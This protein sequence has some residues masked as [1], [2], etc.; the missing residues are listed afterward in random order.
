MKCPHT[1]KA[2]DHDGAV[3]CCDCG[4][5]VVWPPAA[6]KKLKANGDALP[7]PS[8]PTLAKPTAPR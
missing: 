1:M 8:K 5:M 2:T 3:F 4:R 7:P 6:R